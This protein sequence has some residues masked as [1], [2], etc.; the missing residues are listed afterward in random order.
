MS[1][2]EIKWAFHFFESGWAEMFRDDPSVQTACW[3]PASPVLLQRLVLQSSLVI[4][5]A[6]LLVSVGTLGTL[7]QVP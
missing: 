3:T 4:Q 2:N 7:K 6:V 5:L 1:Q